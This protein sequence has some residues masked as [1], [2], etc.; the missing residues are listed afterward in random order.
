M[1][2][3]IIKKLSRQKIGYKLDDAYLNRTPQHCCKRDSMA[4]FCNAIKTSNVQVEPPWL[5]CKSIIVFLS[6]VGLQGSLKNGSHE[7]P[8]ISTLKGWLQGRVVHFLHH[9][10]IFCKV[11]CIYMLLSWHKRKN[12]PNLWLNLNFQLEEETL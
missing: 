7:N 9:N 1:T 10:L 3:W 2:L 4:A 5:F 11:A 8:S 6:R 12:F